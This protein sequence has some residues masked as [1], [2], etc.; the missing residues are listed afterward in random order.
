MRKKLGFFFAITLI[1]LLLVFVVQNLNAVELSF[2]HLS[3]EITL[4]GPILAAY[5]LGGLTARPISRFLNGQRLARKQERKS[6]KAAATKLRKSVSDK[7]VLAEADPAAKAPSDDA[8]T[9]S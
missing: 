7:V 5:L 2:L 1:L 6:D 9:D 4:A 3:G 8:S